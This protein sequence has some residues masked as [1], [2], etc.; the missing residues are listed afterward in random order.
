LGG[1]WMVE[2]LTAEIEELA[3]DYLRKIDDMG[4]AVEAIESGWM[5]K[6]IEESAFK[7]AQGTDSGS[8]VVVG[9]NKFTA[10]SEEPVE[11]MQLDPELGQRQVDRLA[12]IRRERDQAVVDASLKTLSEAAKGT[13]NLLY[14][15]REALAAHATLGEVS[16]VLREVFGEY[17]P[18]STI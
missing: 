18:A 8:R 13:D 14:P 17:E 9:V 16:D 4:G 2:S 12:K 3:R 10:E 5:K 7:I 11:I 1:S 6:E 15:M